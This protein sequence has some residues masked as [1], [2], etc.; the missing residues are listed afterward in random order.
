MIL[1]R[2]INEEILSR[3]M[4]RADYFNE[5]KSGQ[6]RAAEKLQRLNHIIFDGI[7]VHFVH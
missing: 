4:M 5:R 3:K 7:D 6:S 1:S 2:R